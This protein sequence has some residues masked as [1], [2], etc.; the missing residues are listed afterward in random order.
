MRLIDIHPDLGI[1][2][3]DCTAFQAQLIGDTPDD[4][5]K[6]NELHVPVG[7]AVKLTMTSEDVIHSFFVPAFRVKKD[8]V[9]GRYN[10]A[11]F[12]ANRTGTYHLFCAEYCGTNHSGM[13]GKVVV[14]DPLEYEQWLASS[15]NTETMVS[16]GEQLYRQ[17]GCPACHQQ[18]SSARGPMLRGL[19]GSTVRLQGG[20]T[21][22][23]DREY[24]RESISDPGAKVVEGYS[25]IMPTYRTT[26]NQEQL[27]QIVEYLLSLDAGRPM[28]A[29]SNE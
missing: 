14:M 20:R 27:N 28:T 7:R 25:P 3:D 26:L 21:V 2:A 8:A 13:I 16:A 22:I 19:A 18:E 9:P 23:A 24:M 6:M 10:V 17:Y 12:E 5:V 1:R 29:R 4:I 11:W 15:G